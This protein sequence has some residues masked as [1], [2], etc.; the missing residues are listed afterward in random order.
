VPLADAMTAPPVWA[1][2]AQRQIAARMLND[3]HALAHEAA[4]RPNAR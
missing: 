4:L 2:S 1:T 3:V